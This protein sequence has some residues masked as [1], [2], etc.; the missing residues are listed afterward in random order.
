MIIIRIRGRYP[1]SF[2]GSAYSTLAQRVAYYY[3]IET[4][5]PQRSFPNIADPTC[6]HCGG[7]S[8]VQ[9]DNLIVGRC[10]RLTRRGRNTV[11]GH[12][13]RA[14]RTTQISETPILKY[15]DSEILTTL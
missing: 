8:W 3:N 6:S 4:A 15:S 13:D 2:V 1:F 10:C 14:D 12:Y 9:L 11:I 7:G 5:L